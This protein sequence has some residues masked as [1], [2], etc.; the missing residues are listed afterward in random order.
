VGGVRVA[1]LALAVLAVTAC[2]KQEEPS[3]NPLLARVDGSDVYQS[4]MDAAWSRTFSEVDALYADDAME[5][6]LL[7]SLVASRVMA[8]KAEATMSAEQ[9]QEFEAVVKA[10]REEQLVKRYLSEHVTPQPVSNEMVESYYNKHP[11]MFGGGERRLY[12]VL[13]IQGTTN[14]ETRDKAVALLGNAAAQKEWQKYARENSSADLIVHYARARA[15]ANTG[16]KALL[17]KLKTLSAGKT[18]AMSLAG[19]EATVLRVNAVEIIAPRP[20]IEVRDDIRRR[21]APV[22]LKAAV[23]EAMD[24]ALVG[25]DVEYFDSKN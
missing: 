7:K 24:T 11:E 21:L 18:S 25:A 23:K 2:G 8:H 15:D 17:A 9:K 10:W 4:D 1:A 14:E 22:N 20:L 13:T 5:E 16:D 12:E 6:R 19:G 3:V